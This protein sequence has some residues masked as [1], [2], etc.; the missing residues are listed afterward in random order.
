MTKTLR[1]QQLHTRLSSCISFPQK[2][3]SARAARWFHLA[4]LQLSQSYF[5]RDT[6]LRLRLQVPNVLRSSVAKTL[7]S[8]KNKTGKGHTSSQLRRLVWAVVLY[9]ATIWALAITCLHPQTSGQLP[10]LLEFAFFCIQKEEVDGYYLPRT[11]QLLSVL[12]AAF[13]FVPCLGERSVKEDPRLRSKKISARNFIY[14]SED[15]SFC[16][17]VN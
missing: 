10:S 8:N 17:H 15:T 6:M 1:S 13:S 14:C 3:L 9:A 16:K 5:K 7:I 4:L 12:T 11:S 2:V